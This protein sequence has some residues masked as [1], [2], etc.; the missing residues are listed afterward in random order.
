MLVA[1]GVFAGS[2]AL[3][4]ASGGIHPRFALKDAA[5]EQVQRT[6]APID[7]RL[8][9]G[10][11]CHDIDYIERNSYHARSAAPA[12]SSWDVGPA[13]AARFAPLVHRDPAVTSTTSSA[14]E[15]WVG[16]DGR[17]PM[18][19]VLCH[20]AR[21]NLAARARALRAGELAWEVTA[22]LEGVASIADGARWRY[23]PD[24]FDDEGLVR[25]TTLELTSARSSHCLACHGGL[26]VER[27]AHDPRAL[28]DAA[29]LSPGWATGLAYSGRVM[30]SVLGDDPILD[31]PFDVHAERGVE[32]SNCHHS[33]NH[34]SYR[35]KKDF[36]RIEH[37]R[38]DARAVDL[39]SYVRRPSH[40]L[41]TG[42]ASQSFLGQKLPGS[43]RRCEDCH[44]A[45]TAHEWLPYNR[46]S[47]SS[48]GRC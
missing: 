41:V 2:P 34:P 43:M 8:T 39:G 30:K 42:R 40:E 33:I 7:V 29:T 32:C 46:C 12:A 5:G 24:I 28:V 14:D 47:S 35:G 26:D 38:F 44:A 17:R 23:A 27:A 15:R 36:S 21:P 16:G 1:I 37:L 9:C 10:G 22:T 48:T 4:A 6:G 13:L 3:H 25:S 11:D 19:C 20:V 31:R 18:N 45:D